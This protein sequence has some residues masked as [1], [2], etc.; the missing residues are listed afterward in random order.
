MDGEDVDEESE[1]EE[2]DDEEELEAIEQRGKEKVRDILTNKFSNFKGDE[3]KQ[4]N[5]FQSWLEEAR[6][7][8]EVL[9]VEEGQLTDEQFSGLLGSARETQAMEVIGR[10]R[11]D[12][13]YKGDQIDGMDKLSKI[14]E[15]VLKFYF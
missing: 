11:S 15:Q 14:D 3:L 5:R 12:K 6:N 2:E 9:T 7:E 13:E 1:S 10:G 4:S 8:L